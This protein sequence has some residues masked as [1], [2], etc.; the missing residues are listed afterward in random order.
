MSL[1]KIKRTHYI[2]QSAD[3]CKM[4]HSCCLR[5]RKRALLSRIG[6]LKGIVN[7]AHRCWCSTTVAKITNLISFIYCDGFS[8]T[9]PLLPNRRSRTCRMAFCSD[10]SL[11][12]DSGWSSSTCTTT[13]RMHYSSGQDSFL[14]VHR[15][16]LKWSFVHANETTV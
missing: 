3:G 9:S 1:K 11:A 14:H 10:S 15:H 13:R 7:D 2:V 16:H 5:T 8:A 6:F 4:H 12:A